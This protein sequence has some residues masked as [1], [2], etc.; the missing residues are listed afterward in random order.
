MPLLKPVRLASQTTATQPVTH[1]SDKPLPSTSFAC[2]ASQYTDH[3]FDQQ[4]DP[5]SPVHPIGE[6]GEVS[7]EETGTAE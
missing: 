2:A 6:E 3:G 1:V 4:S 7:N 5:T